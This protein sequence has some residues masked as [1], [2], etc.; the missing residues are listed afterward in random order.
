MVSVNP[1]MIT[2]IDTVYIQQGRDTQR[3]L[4]VEVLQR[5][6]NVNYILIT[7]LFTLR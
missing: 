1:P 5:V 3:I 2:N 7:N 4:E 6:L